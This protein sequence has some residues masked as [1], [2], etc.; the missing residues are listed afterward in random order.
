MVGDGVNDSPAL[1]AADV[2]MAVGS[3]TDI[4]IEAADYVLMRDD[5]EVRARLSA[6]SCGQALGLDLGQQRKGFFVPVSLYLRSRRQRRAVF[7]GS[8]RLAPR[9]PLSRVST[10]ERRQRQ[11]A[12]HCTRECDAPP[13]SARRGRAPSGCARG[14]RPVAQ[15]VRPHPAQLLLRDGVQRGHDP[16]RRRHLLPLHAHAG[17]RRARRARRLGTDSARWRRAART[18]CVSCLSRPRGA[19][20]WLAGSDKHGARRCRP[21]RPARPWPSARSAW[22]APR[23]CCAATAARRACCAM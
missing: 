18:R 6:R 16:V 4:A 7:A 17:A 23:C 5:L 10:L 2:G 22:C 3:G 14:D 9:R 19:A 8:L 20:V 1:A 21:G 12:G 15:D 11:R 13:L